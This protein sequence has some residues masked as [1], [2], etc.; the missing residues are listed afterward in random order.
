MKIKDLFKGNETTTALKITNKYFLFIEKIGEFAFGE[1]VGEHLLIELHERLGKTLMTD[2][3]ETLT[4]NF[5]LETDIK[6][7]TF[8]KIKELATYGL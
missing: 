7:L 8:K 4:H 3:I 6:E 2:Y 1:K 5:T